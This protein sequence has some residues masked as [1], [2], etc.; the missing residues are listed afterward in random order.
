MTRRQ[1]AGVERLLLYGSFI[2]TLFAVATVP[3]GASSHREA[4]FVTEHSKVDATDFYMFRSYESDRTGYVTIIANYIPMQNAYGGP[5]FFTLDPE[6]LYEIHIDNNGDAK[7]DLT[8]QFKFTNTLRNITLDIGPEGNTKKVAIPLINAGAISPVDKSLLNVLE[9]YTVNLTRGDR[10][11]GSSSSITN[12]DTGE[13]TFTKPVDD[14][15]N[16]SIVDYEAYSR[17]HIYNI[18]IPGTNAKGRLFVG[19]RKDPFVVNLGPAFDLV[20]L[21]PLGPEDGASNSLANNN[22]TTLALEIPISVLKSGG[23]SVIG[24]WTTASLP[25]NR[26]LSSS[27]TFTKPDKEMGPWIQ[28]SR[29]GMPL[30]NELV[31]GIKDKDRFN[32]SEPQK[33][34][35]FLTYVTN[36]T[37]PALLQ[38][39]FGVRAPTA[40]PRSDLVAVFLTGV[41]GLNATATPAEYLRLNTKTTPVARESQNTLGVI[42]GDNAGF[43][44]GRRPGDDVVDVALRVV[45]G[46]LLDSSVA[47]DGQLKYT[48]GAAINA[49]MF[50]D[51]FPYLEPPVPGAQ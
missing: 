20:N 7:E 12:A 8:F 3:A 48:D 33:D 15:G 49:K 21:N 35:Q 47:P 16:K 41:S 23:S 31:I 34:T 36:P 22:V 9:T 50:G 43:P 28:V 24:G 19:Q 51:E 44:N 4:P 25:K 1:P 27:P 30:V 6:A 29:L 2:T 38:A 45:M 40:F 46:K 26:V 37:L 5:N 10:R 17:A 18:K 39:L 11:T 13:D 42:G 32:A 14:I